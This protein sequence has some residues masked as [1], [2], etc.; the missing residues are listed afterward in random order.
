MTL[1][2]SA[3]ASLLNH[4]YGGSDYTRPATVSLALFTVAPNFETGSGGTE[5]TGGSYARASVTS[6]TTNFPSASGAVKSNGAAIAFPTPTANWGT[7]VAFGWYDGATLLAGANLTAQKV[8]NTGDEVSF[9]IG[10]LTFTWSSSDASTYLMNGLLDHI[11]GGPDF[12]RP[13]TL[14]F[15]L[16][17]TAPTFSSGT[18]GTELSGSNYSR[19]AYT[20]NS[21][22][23]PA[24]S[25]G[26]TSK[27]NA[28]A[29]TFPVPS[30]AWTIAASGIYDASTSGNFWGG[31]A[32][33]RTANSGDTVRI[34]A[35]SLTLSLA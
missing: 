34:P 1:S 6:N 33:A 18:G 20:N 29:I 27:S 35:S 26:T 24:A 9:A 4:A 10:A 8:F 11:F 30:G 31:F 12:T 19:A 22:N 13:A 32:I 28:N 14:H 15:A 25:S 17:S 3:E 7:V 23:F 2:D 21:T 5:V 16:F